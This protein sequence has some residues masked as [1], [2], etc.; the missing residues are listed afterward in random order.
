MI[1]SLPVWERTALNVKGN[2]IICLAHRVR[3]EDGNAALHDG[4]TFLR[5]SFLAIVIGEFW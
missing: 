4:I 1:D 2:G 3:T 5:G